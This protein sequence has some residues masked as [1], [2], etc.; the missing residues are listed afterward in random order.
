MFRLN[1]KNRQSRIFSTNLLLHPNCIPPHRHYA[2]ARKPCAISTKSS[3]IRASSVRLLFFFFK[4]P[5]T[6]P[7]RPLPPFISHWNCSLSSYSSFLS[8]RA[9]HPPTLTPISTFSQDAHSRF[10]PLHPSSFHLLLPPYH[11]FP[12]P[13]LAFFSR[14]SSPC[15]VNG[16][17]QPP[18]RSSHLRR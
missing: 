14:R 5:T 11:R 12:S 2:S 7:R 1:E 4:L 3:K 10:P 6:S 8:N 18:F 15:P 17:S 13:S 16:H 9:Q